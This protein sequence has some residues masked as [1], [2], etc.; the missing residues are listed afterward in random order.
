MSSSGRYAES[1]TPI[2]GSRRFAP[3]LGGIGFAVPASAAAVPEISRFHGIVIG[4]Y[5]EE[6]GRPHFHARAGGFKISV[7]IETGIIRGDFPSASLKRV[8]D[9]ADLHRTEL[10]DN[11]SLARRG[12]PLVSIPPLP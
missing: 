4:M 12:E 8:A 7:E 11:W 9:W 10:M 2:S 1:P 5:Y 3:V 6:H